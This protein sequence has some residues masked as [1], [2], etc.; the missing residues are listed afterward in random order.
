MAE[1]CDSQPS[2]TH[3]CNQWVYGSQCVELSYLDTMREASLP[4]I[5]TFFFCSSLRSSILNIPGRI[6][7]RTVT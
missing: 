6:P 3:S 7:L 4:I 5:S 2:A 1:D